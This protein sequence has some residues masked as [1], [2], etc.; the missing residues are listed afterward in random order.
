MQLDRIE[1]ADIHAPKRLARAVLDQIGTLNSPVMIPGP[2]PVIEIARALDIAEVRIG[3][4]DG[5]EGML[6]TDAV[7]SC[8]AIM[9]NNKHGD[10]RARFTIAHELGH[11]LLERHVPTD[12]KGF[13]CKVADLRETRTGQ[14]H[15]RQESEANTFAIELLAPPALFDRYLSDAPDIKDALQA[16]DG[17]DLSLEAC[18][19]RML[20]RRDEPLALVFSH[21]GRVR[22]VIRDNGLPYL[23]LNKGDPMPSATPASIK[24]RQGRVGISEPGPNVARAWF[25]K[26]DFDLHEQTRLADNG[27]AVTLLWSDL[28]VEAEDD[29]GAPPELGVPRFR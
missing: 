11:F 29:D 24:I 22:Y 19:R 1:L 5:F 7:R 2:V 9:A 13:A 8:G 28:P 12:P 18:L 26:A 4:F 16:R 6:L 15:R 27:H 10:R 23:P 21:E 20:E 3:G 14:W 25:D 17:L